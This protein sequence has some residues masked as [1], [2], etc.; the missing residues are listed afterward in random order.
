M[1]QSLARTCQVTDQLLGEQRLTILLLQEE[2]AFVLLVLRSPAGLGI[3][4]SLTGLQSPYETQ[5]WLSRVLNTF[6]RHTPLRKHYP[7]SQN[8]HLPPSC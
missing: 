3:V 7:T 5:D 1:L 8:E 4:P 2:S 6:G